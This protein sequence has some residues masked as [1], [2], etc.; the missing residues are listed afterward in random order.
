MGRFGERVRTLTRNLTQRLRH[1][2]SSGLRI[3]VGILLDR[4]A[5]K[6]LHARSDLHDACLARRRVRQP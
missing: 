4:I 5:V 6:R 2:R 1:T 3:F